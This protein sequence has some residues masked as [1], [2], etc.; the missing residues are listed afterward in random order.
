MNELKALLEVRTAVGSVPAADVM[1]LALYHP[2]HGYYRRPAGP[3]GFEGGDYYTA[4]D[5]GPLLGET[6][7]LRLEEVWRDLGCPEVFTVLEPGAGRGWLGRDLL[8]AASGGFASALRY[9]HQDDN[10]AARATSREA[11]SP[12]IA[13][14]QARWVAEGETLEP[15]V[16]AVVS[17]E[18]FDAL[19]AQPWR[20]TGEA[21]EREVLTVEGA[22]WEPSDPGPAGGWF[23]SRAEGGLEPGDGSL[24]CEGLPSLVERLA[25]PLERGLFLAIDYGESAARLLAKG[26]DLRRYRAHQVDGRWWDDLGQADLTADVDLTRLARCLEE[27]GLEPAPAQSLGRWIRTHA[28]LMDW[29][30]AWQD[31]DPAARRARMENLLALTLPGMMGDR[32]KVLEARRA[33]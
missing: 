7:T 23:A 10:P 33:V 20:W 25:R 9:L 26:A 4:L 12:W 5:C 16:G 13:T 17:N 30:A 3:W 14:G 1:A 8:K 18:L 15:F 19:P 11:L 6:L 29:E 27:A 32:F 31:L 24:W 2:E 28:P 21:W 22:S